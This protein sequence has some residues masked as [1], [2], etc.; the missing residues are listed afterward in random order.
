MP[1]RKITVDGIARLPAFCHAAIAGSQVLVS[2]ILGVRPGTMDLVDGGVG[3]ETTQTLVNI[4]T[5]LR[6]CGCEMSDV[7]K[8]NVFLTDMAQF[9]TMNEAYVA[10]IGADPPARITVGCTALALG[11]SVEMDCIAFLPGAS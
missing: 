4:A 5:I 7:A 3:P 10:A 8:V 2:G 9:T 1:L 6:S 11:A